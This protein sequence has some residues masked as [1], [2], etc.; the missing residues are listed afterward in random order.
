MLQTAASD[1]A[2]YS[3]TMENPGLYLASGRHRTPASWPP[4]QRLPRLGGH[5]QQLFRSPA[6]TTRPATINGAAGRHGQLLG[7]GAGR[8]TS[9]RAKWTASSGAWTRARARASC[10]IS[11]RQGRAGKATYVA[12]DP[13]VAPLIETQHQPPSVQLKTPIGARL[14][15]A[16]RCF[17]TW[18]DPAPSRCQPG[19]A[20]TMLADYVKA[21]RSTRNLPVVLGQALSSRASRA[22]AD[23]TDVAVGPAGHL[24]TR[25]P[26][27]AKAASTR[28]TGQEPAEQPLHQHFPRL[29]LRHASPPPTCSYEI[30]R[31]PARAAAA[32]GTCSYL[33]KPIDA[34]QEFVIATNTTAATSVK[35][36]KNAKLDGS[37]AIW[38]SPMPT[39]RECIGYGASTAAITRAANGGPRAGASPRWPP[40]PSGVQL[41]RQRAARGPGPRGWTTSRC[42]APDDG[43]GKPVRPSTAWT[44]PNK[45]RERPAPPGAGARAAASS[46]PGGSSNTGRLVRGMGIQRAG[47]APTRRASAVASWRPAVQ[48]AAFAPHARHAGGQA[49]DQVR[50]PVAVPSAESSSAANQPPCTPPMGFRCAGPGRPWN[51]ALPSSTEISMKSS[52]RA[53]GA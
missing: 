20:R 28:S 1:G 33:G 37:S 52:V 44:S 18:A 8:D 6:W 3:T 16:A 39:R 50:C 9:W 27:A 22:G 11:R 31:D 36:Y 21:R 26:A 49:L 47:R 34:A 42:V 29:Q 13:T 25:R 23:Y 14:P 32:S 45:R 53:M 30:A 2:A 51:T 12:E 41:R 15:H 46:A 17:A 24:T 38:A 4:A 19:A 5:V 10:A 43:S 7:Q 40:R 48:H 35:G